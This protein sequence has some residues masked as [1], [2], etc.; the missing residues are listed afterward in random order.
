MSVNETNKCF[1]VLYQCPESLDTESV[2]YHRQSPSNGKIDHEDPPRVR[3]SE[4]DETP[5]VKLCSSRRRSQR[6]T[7]SSRARRRT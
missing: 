3:W 4:D 6:E 2:V 7:R 1:P 5:V